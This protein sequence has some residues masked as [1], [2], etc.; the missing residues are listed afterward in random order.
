MGIKSK[1]WAVR[2]EVPTLVFWFLCALP[3]GFGIWV[4][5]R[6]LRRFFKQLGQHCTFHSNFRVTNPEKI[7][8]GNHCG[9]ASGVFLTGGGGIT[10]GN[11]V[12]IGPD[13]KV[14]SVNH[15][16][17]D[18]ELPWMK[19]GYDHDPVVIEDDV[20]LGANVFIMPGVTIGR[21]AIV[22]AGTV[23]SKSVPA[24]AIAAG[25]PG[26]VVGWRKHPSTA[27]DPIIALPPIEHRAGTS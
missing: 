20:W 5:E 11:Y 6:T 16:F 24:F 1:Y 25:N 4:R 8:I 10:I 21:G 26:R 14:W 3:A 9:F 15:R 22:S 18:P 12:G 2:S 7:S 13:S 17:T 19:Q 27:S 23:L